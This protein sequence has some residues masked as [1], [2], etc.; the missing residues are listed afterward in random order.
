MNDMVDT[1]IEMPNFLVIGAA[2]SGT[3]SL[4]RYLSQHPEISMSS[5]K[6]PTYFLRHEEKELHRF[7]IRAR[8]EYLAIFESGFALRGEAS[9][10][11]SWW[12]IHDEVPA[13]IA[14]EVPE[15][16]FVYIVRDPIDR[17]VSQ[18][19]QLRSNRE[20]ES[21]R[22]FR[23]RPLSEALRDPEPALNFLIAP[24]LY[25]TQIRQ[26][27]KF[28]PRESILVVDSDA[29]RNER[30]RTVEE[31]LDFLGA[32]PMPSGVDLSVEHNRFEEKREEANAYIRLTESGLL[33]GLF[34]R[35]P[36]PLRDRAVKVARRRFSRKIPRPQLDP[37]DREWLEELFRPEV[38]E[39]REFTAR[40][41]PHWSI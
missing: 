27:L 38:K 40:T 33:R 20:M 15:M 11:Y 26:Y 28:F 19:V 1:N 37:A 31:V 9:V 23:S 10:R 16:K 30:A 14:A 41:F 29:L 24:S 35:V 36:D 7:Q 8:D 3:K 2:K 25:M 34:D 12:P 6:E 4:H 18:Y 21:R 17:A 22:A 5:T 39:L 32:G 13:A